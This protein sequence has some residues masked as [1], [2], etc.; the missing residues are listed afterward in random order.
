MVRDCENGLSEPESEKPRSQH[1]GYPGL[2]RLRNEDL[3]SVPMGCGL[4]GTR[5]RR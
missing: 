4:C 2:A 5:I 3:A 1:W